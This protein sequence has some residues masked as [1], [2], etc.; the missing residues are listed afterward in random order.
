MI[1]GIDK[2]FK[3]EITPSTNPR[4]KM[5]KS[6]LKPHMYMVESSN[7]DKTWYSAMYYYQE[8]GIV[9]RLGDNKVVGQ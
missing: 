3:K 2:L 5:T 7:G 8:D 1:M 9:M 4:F 6:G